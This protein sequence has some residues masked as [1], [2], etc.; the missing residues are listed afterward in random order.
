MQNTGN[1]VY[2]FLISSN[3]AFIAKTNGM[4]IANHFISFKSGLFYDKASVAC[5]VKVAEC[6]G[7]I[8]LNE[9]A[10][11]RAFGKSEK[12]ISSSLT[13]LAKANSGIIA[14]H[15]ISFISGHVQDKA[16]VAYSIE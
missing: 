5:N 9:T 16:S 2:G 8:V 13:F 15:F 14:N 4:I 7:Y 3:S 1:V 12:S 10:H 11:L 6:L